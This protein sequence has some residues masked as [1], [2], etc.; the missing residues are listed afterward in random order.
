[1]Y[2]SL[3]AVLS[4]LLTVHSEAVSQV[5]IR[6]F[7]RLTEKKT[8]KA[9]TYSWRLINAWFIVSKGLALCMHFCTN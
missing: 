9:L 6:P 5:K 4:T 2:I 3:L 7:W 8:K 1:M